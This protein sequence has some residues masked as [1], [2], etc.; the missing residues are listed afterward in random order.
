MELRQYWGIF[1][2][3]WGL[4]FLGALIGAGSGYVASKRT[5]PVYSAATTLLVNQASSP[6][7]LRLAEFT[8]KSA[9]PA[10]A[11]SL[12]RRTCSSRG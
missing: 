10:R 2:R 8:M 3:W 12:R 7:P 6:L 11:A 5:I 4:L 1:L 9:T